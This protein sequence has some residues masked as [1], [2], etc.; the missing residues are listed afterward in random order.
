MEILKIP[1]PPTLLAIF[2]FFY[3]L[4]VQ[5]KWSLIQL[6]WLVT[7]KAWTPKIIIDIE[8]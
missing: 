4:P 8:N 7:I 5:L 2:S 3:T 6:N 1:P